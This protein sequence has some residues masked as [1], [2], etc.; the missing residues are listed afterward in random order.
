MPGADGPPSDIELLRRHVAGDSEAFGELFRRHRDR[1]WAVAVRTLH[2]PEDAADA[3]QEAM[4]SA[5]RRA[6]SFRGDSAVTTWLHRIVVNACLDRMRR[7]A[8]RPEVAGGDERLLDTMARTTG[9]DPAH[10]SEVAVE[11]MT[12][13][14]QLPHD[15][16][17]A[18]VL[19]DMLEYPVA[20]AAQLLGVA[21]GTVKSR[22]ARGR[23]RLLPR[24][25]HLRQSGGRGTKESA[26]G[27]ESSEGS[28]DPDGG[29]RFGP[30]SV[31]PAQE[32]SDEAH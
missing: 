2:D 29:N 30:E 7:R 11:V 18:L 13:L 27:S 1:L 28:A 23:A 10:G 12:A 20:E 16:Q 32:G 5:F 3:L 8:A 15:Q 17:V 6:G 25:A 14:R 24:L 26:A 19:V 4:I 9:A 21:Q 22:C 31:L